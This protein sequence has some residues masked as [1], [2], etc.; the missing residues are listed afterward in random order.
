[1]TGTIRERRISQH[2]R[3]TA[4]IRARIVSGDWAPGFQL[5]VET[6]MAERY[7]VSR[8]TMNKALTRLS[9]EGFLLRRKKRGT[10]VAQ[11]R[12][13]SAVMEIADIEADVRALGRSHRFEL[14]ARTEAGLSLSEASEIG[15]DARVGQSA[16]TL[17]GLHSADGRPFCLE[18]RLINPKLADGVLAADFS[19]TAPGGWLLRQ[20]PWTEASHRI[21]A[22]GATASIA[23]Q[24]GLDPGEAC[25]EVARRTRSGDGWV[26]WAQLIYPGEA[27]QLVADF[28]PRGGAD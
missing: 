7:G 21:R 20:V 15:L 3:I 28:A 9:Q 17:R 11:P 8:M 12:A 16:L 2:E 10:V 23:R 27:H 25:L 6:E 19:E 13:Q 24:L 14:S 22:V 4:E 5:P 18:T 1:M 26:T